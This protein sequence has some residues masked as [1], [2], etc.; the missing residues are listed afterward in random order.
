MSD[1]QSCTITQKFGGTSVGSAEAIARVAGIVRRVREN[2]L[3]PTPGVAARRT[4]V[5]VSA[6][7]G[8]TNELVRAAQM[9]VQ[10]RDDVVAEI[11]RA[12]RE[13]HRATLAALAADA[14]GPLEESERL[15]LGHRIE[16]LLDYVQ[17]L[18]RATSILGECT[19]RG[20][21]VISGLGERLAVHL[22]AAALQARGVPAQAVEATEL[23]VTDDMYGAANPLLDETRARVRAR[24][25]PMLD[26]GVTPVVTGFIGATRDG[27]P[28]TLGRGGSD[29]SATLVGACLDSNEIWIWSDVDGVMSA[30]PRVVPE[31]QTIETLSYA[32]AAE[33]S[34][35]GAK[36]I[37]PKT[38]LPAVEREIPLRILNSFAPEGSGTRI[39]ADPPSNGRVV[40]GITAIKQVSEITV[41]GRGM[42]GIP[43]IAARVFSAVAA[44]QVNVLMIS[45]S[46]SEQ[47]ICFVVPHDAAGRT[48]RA[49]EEAFQYDI[50]RHNI[51]QV[52]S[53]DD[54]AILAI[55]GER[56]KGTVGI[57]SRLFGALSEQGIN[58][59]TI[60]Q[61]S[62][63]YNI[64]LVIAAD[65]VDRA[66]RAVHAT[67]GLGRSPSCPEQ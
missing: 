34:Y 40:K 59:L 22:V 10:G 37:H 11:V 3:H 13:R 2:T 62:S 20:M 67:Y 4:A 24:L 32:E 27:T 38:I 57:A 28:T 49:L 5:V 43:G 16:D 25:R 41:A 66:V 1:V 17:S 54:V 8:V 47:S 36:V 61:G 19:A 39:L 29:Y 6:M 60:A 52:W 50:L 65:Q 18:C 58:I 35:F 55:V 26:A 53:A 51:E 33:F 21:D 44:E 7:S 48:L 31:A 45:Q 23:L 9:A 15:T 12:L 30:D 56:M 42:L 63:E 64:S 46:S 14:E